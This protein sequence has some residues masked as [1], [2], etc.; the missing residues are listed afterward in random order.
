MFLKG[1][2]QIGMAIS[3][4]YVRYEKFFNVHRVDIPSQQSGIDLIDGTEVDTYF[5]CGQWGP[6]PRLS[7]CNITLAVDVAA[8]QWH[9][10]VLTSTLMDRVAGWAWR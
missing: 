6:N 10:W 1:P 7:N 2:R 3:N 9:R 8:N 4:P 5:D